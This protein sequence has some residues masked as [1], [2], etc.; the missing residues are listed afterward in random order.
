[1]YLLVVSQEKDHLQTRLV[2]ASKLQATWM[3][4]TLEDDKWLLQS[5]AHVAK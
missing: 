2:L 3:G 1:M 5:F 4:I